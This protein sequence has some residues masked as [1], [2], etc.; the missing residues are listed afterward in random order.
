MI[1]QESDRELPFRLLI[2]NIWG[3]K[4]FRVDSSKMVAVATAHALNFRPPFSDD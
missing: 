2:H 1:V 3:I 4:F